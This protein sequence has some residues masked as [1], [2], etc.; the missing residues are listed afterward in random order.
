MET[1]KP[2][3]WNDSD[4]SVE[5]IFLHDGLN[6]WIWL[7]PP[8]MDEGVSEWLNEWLNDWMTEWMNEWV[9]EWLNDWVIEWVNEWMNERIS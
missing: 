1:G 2:F 4:E 8:W 5:I 7:D 3:V 9:N 6:E